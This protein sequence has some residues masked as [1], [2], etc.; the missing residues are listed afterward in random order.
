MKEMGS[1]TLR[2]R[3]LIERWAEHNDEH[4]ARFRESAEEAE[5]LGFT[6]AAEKLRR[7][8]EDASKVSERLREA[9]QALGEH[10]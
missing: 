10:N 8:S 4:K 7:A 9:L 1:E 2:L 3:R 6:E 5:R